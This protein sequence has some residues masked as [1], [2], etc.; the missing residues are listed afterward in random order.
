MNDGGDG[1]GRGRI[2]FASVGDAVCLAG[3]RYHWSA[4]SQGLSWEDVRI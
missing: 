1:G 4:L 2:S 3:T